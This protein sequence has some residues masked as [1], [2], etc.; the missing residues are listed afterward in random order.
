MKS[1]PTLNM[2]KKA[3]SSKNK[4]MKQKYQCPC[5]SFFLSLL[6]NKKQL[7]SS[8]ISEKVTRNPESVKKASKSTVLKSNRKSRIVR[9]PKIGCDIPFLVALF[10]N[11]S[12]NGTVKMDE[13][14]IM[15]L[16][17]ITAKVKKDLDEGKKWN[18]NIEIAENLQLRL[19]KTGLILYLK[20]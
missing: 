19:Y 2:N 15:K 3:T 16:V 5:I 14:D 1:K 6:Q 11:L 4:N 7:Q 10:T 20:K 13:R 18:G 12:N 8:R 9:I 17:N